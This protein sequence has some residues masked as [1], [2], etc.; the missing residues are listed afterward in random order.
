M[1]SSDS[2]PTRASLQIDS[3]P[4]SN[5]RLPRAPINGATFQKPTANTTTPKVPETEFEDVGLN[6]ETNKPKKRGFLSRFGDTTSS[7]TTPPGSSDGSKMGGHFGFHLTG[8]KRGQSGTGAEL[9]SMER[10]GSA[11]GSNK[12]VEGVIR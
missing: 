12:V 7:E 1:P 10:P 6:D 3:R 8:R 9:G 4:P 5:T 11:K 2:F